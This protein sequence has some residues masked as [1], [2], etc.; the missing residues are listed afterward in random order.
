MAGCSIRLSGVIGFPA[1]AATDLSRRTVLGGIHGSF[2]K[3]TENWRYPWDCAYHARARG[4]R[5]I[6]GD[7]I[8]ASC[9]IQC[10]PHFLFWSFHA[11]QP[12]C[13]SFTSTRPHVSSEQV[14]DHDVHH[15]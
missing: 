1:R 12:D 11:S 6:C 5:L 2:T 13:P 8:S 7:S 15:R 14:P 4:V 9:P 3:L 10:T